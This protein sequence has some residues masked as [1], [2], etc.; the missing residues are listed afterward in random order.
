MALGWQLGADVLL[1]LTWPK[2]Q[3][4]FYSGKIFEYL[5]ARRNIL[6]IPGDGDVVDSLLRETGAGISIET[7]EEVASKLAEWQ[8]EKTQYGVLTYMGRE[9]EITKY[10]RRISTGKLSEILDN[11]AR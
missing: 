4:G 5:Y 11:I 8:R 1:H 2:G 10:D 6:A 3:K 7:P 9:K